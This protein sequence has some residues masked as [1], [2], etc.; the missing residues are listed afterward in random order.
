MPYWDMAPPSLR[1]RSIL[2][3]GGMSLDERGVRALTPWIIPRS[4][5]LYASAAISALRAGSTRSTELFAS[6]G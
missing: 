1:W 3:N 4:A 6:F 5:F 2:L